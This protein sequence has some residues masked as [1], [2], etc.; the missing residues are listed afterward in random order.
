MI[1]ANCSTNIPAGASFCPQCGQALAASTMAAAEPSPAAQ[2]R[3]RP[4]PGAAAG[5]DAEQELWRGGFSP[6]AMLGYW[7]LAAVVTIAALAASAIVPLPLVWLVA[8]VVTVTLW[9]VFAGY[10]VYER[11]SVE[12]T[13]TTQRFIHK[14]GILRRLTNRIEAIDIDDVTFEQGL[15]ERMVGVG[16]IKL[17]SSDISDPR[18]T[19]RGIDDV[20]R[21]ANLIDSTRRDERRKRGLHI[22]TV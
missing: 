18:L 4:T 17:L 8:G 7:L 10:L 14:T 1:C 2:L 21:V 22:E 3:E 19:L 12:Y 11:L 16:T 5:S 6:K 15:F 9:L 20:Q 13:L